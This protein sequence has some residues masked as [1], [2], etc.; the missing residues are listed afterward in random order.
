MF[1]LEER[2]EDTEDRVD[3]GGRRIIKKKKSTEIILREM[4]RDAE[5]YRR[6]AEKERQR[7]DRRLE[8]FNQRADNDRQRWDR[9]LEEFN[10]R[11]DKDRADWRARM[12]DSDRKADKDR[13]DWQAR[14]DKDRKE[15]RQARGE[16]ARQ[17]GD[18]SNRIGTLV[19]DIISPSLRR[20]AGEELGCGALQSFTARAERRHAITGRSREFDAIY[21]GDRA[22]LLNESK[23]TARPE[24]A[25]KFVEFLQSGEFFQYFPEYKGRPT[26]PVFSSLYLPESL[27]AYLT[28][29]GIYAVGM[30]EEAMEVLNRE[31]VSA[32]RSAA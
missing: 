23:A 15:D 9:R 30:G 32:L 24:Y 6:E 13:A 12:E 8:E 18:I 29:Q 10:Q 28:K 26:V 14:A 21:A 19:E 1:D 16:L 17:L 7:W 27:V 2:V 25:Q 22:V 4:R 20:L 5:Q 11:A 3:L 31:Q